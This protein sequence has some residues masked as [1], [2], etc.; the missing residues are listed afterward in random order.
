MKERKGEK[1]ECFLLFGWGEKKWGDR[2]KIGWAFSK[3]AHQIFLCQLERKWERKI[4]VWRALK[5][6]EFFALCPSTWFSFFLFV[7]KMDILVNTYKLHFL[8][9]HFYIPQPKTHDEKHKFFLS[10]HFFS[11]S[12]PN[13]ACLRLCNYILKNTLRKLMG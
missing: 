10:S 5:S 2:R 1:I 13:R 6:K 7:I 11:S 12:Q 8:S 9:F 3:R 4:G